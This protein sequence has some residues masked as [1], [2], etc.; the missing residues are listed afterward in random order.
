[1]PQQVPGKRQGS[2][3]SGEMCLMH[4]VQLKASTCPSYIQEEVKISIDADYYFLWTW[5]AVSPGS[6]HISQSVSYNLRDIIENSLTGLP[7]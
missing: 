2:S 6:A 4:W 3:A 5:A 7:Q 1:M